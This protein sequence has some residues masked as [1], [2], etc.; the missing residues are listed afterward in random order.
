MTEWRLL[1]AADDGYLEY[2]V[3]I[4]G[5]IRYLVM[6]SDQAMASIYELPEATGTELADFPVR[7]PVE[8]AHWI[9]QLG[10]DPSLAETVAAEIWSDVLSRR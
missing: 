4:N 5:A 10:M 2:V 6:W 8:I 9:A 7:S 3:T 1:T